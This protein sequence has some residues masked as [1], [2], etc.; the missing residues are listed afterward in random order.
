MNSA[1]CW[2]CLDSHVQTSIKLGVLHVHTGWFL[3][4]LS[5]EYS[6]VITVLKAHEGE[7]KQ[8]VKGESGQKCDV[9][10][11]IQRA[12]LPT[13]AG[14]IGRQMGAR[15]KVYFCNGKTV[16]SLLQSFT[17]QKGELGN[18]QKTQPLS[19]NLM[20]IGHKTKCWGEFYPFCTV[21]ISSVKGAIFGPFEAKYSESN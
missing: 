17:L 10:S 18:V 8:K 15:G 6:S 11:C 4:S 9:N 1:S 14:Q 20:L 5:V 16:D 3:S 2:A 19:A 13:C 7:P 21:W 12:G